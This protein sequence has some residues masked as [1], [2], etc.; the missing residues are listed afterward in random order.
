AYTDLN[1]RFDSGAYGSLFHMLTGFHGFHVIV[2]ASMLTGILFRL[3]TGH[4]TA[5]HHFRFEG[6]ASYRHGADLAWLGFDL[7]V[8]WF[9]ALRIPGCLTDPRH[10]KKPASA[11]F[12][13]VI[14]AQALLI[15][16]QKQD[17]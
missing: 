2:G 5:D 13:H 12:F 4:F 10:R 8:Y 9:Y 17:L 16:S 1:L 6:A 3:I 11:G 15:P 14:D 7:F